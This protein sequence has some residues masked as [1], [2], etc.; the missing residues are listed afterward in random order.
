MIKITPETR[1]HESFA[2]EDPDTGEL[3]VFDVTVL[4]ER[5]EGMG[6]QVVMAQ[7][8]PE[9]RDLFLYRR[10]VEQHRLDRVKFPC[11]P[12]M[13]CIMDDSVLTVD[14]NHRIAKA[15]L[16]DLPAIP[17]RLIPQEVWKPCLLDLRGTPLE[18]ALENPAL[19]MGGF[20]GI[21]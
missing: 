9:D 20:S 3:R 17:I 10:G 15:Y 18:P 7:L 1:L 14:G 5:I 12:V 13:G 19:L 4:R 21:R 6:L 8:Q 16:L 11:A 2:H